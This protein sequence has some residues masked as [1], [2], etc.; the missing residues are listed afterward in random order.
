MRAEQYEE[1]LPFRLLGLG[2]VHWEELAEAKVQILLRA[3]E[4]G[5]EASET[6]IPLL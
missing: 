2:R 1:M 3:G 5:G 4:T 6:A